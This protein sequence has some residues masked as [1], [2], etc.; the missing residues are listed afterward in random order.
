MFHEAAHSLVPFEEIVNREGFFYPEFLDLKGLV[1]EERK[2]W[3][4]S[5]WLLRSL[6]RKG[7]VEFT[8]ENFS[9]EAQN[10]LRTYEE[11][12]GAE[13]RRLKGETGV[14]HHFTGK[15]RKK[16]R[17]KTF[18]KKP[19]VNQWLSLILRKEKAR[20]KV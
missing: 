8:D 3:A 5:Y 2:A 7:F 20:E 6:R 10:C 13:T 17:S 4:A 12:I 18:P 11:G 19:R 1:A 14:E 16:I 15:K 9:L